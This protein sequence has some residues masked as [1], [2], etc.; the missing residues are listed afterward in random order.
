MLEYI[1]LKQNTITFKE[2]LKKFEELNLAQDSALQ[3]FKKANLPLLN[4]SV[5]LE[6]N[7]LVSKNKNKSKL[8][9]PGNDLNKRSISPKLRQM[10][11]NLKEKD[12]YTLDDYLNKDS[13]L[14]GLPENKSKVTFGDNPSQNFD[15]DIPNLFKDGTKKKKGLHFYS[16]EGNRLETDPN[17]VPPE[18]E[19]SK[20]NPKPENQTRSTVV[21]PE[22]F[23]YDDNG[24]RSVSPISKSISPIS[25]SDVSKGRGILTNGGVPGSNRAERSSNKKVK[26]GDKVKSGDGN[27]GTNSGISDNYGQKIRNDIEQIL[28]RQIEERIKY[29]ALIREANQLAGV[30]NSNISASKP[31]SPYDSIRKSLLDQFEYNQTGQKPG[32][33]G[34]TDAVKKPL[35]D[36]TNS[37]LGYLNNWGESASSIAQDKPKA[38]QIFGEM[39]N[40]SQFHS[41]ANS[42]RNNLTPAQIK[43]MVVDYLNDS[44]KQSGR[45]KDI[46]AMGKKNVLGSGQKPEDIDRISSIIAHEI[47]YELPK[48]VDY[49]QESIVKQAVQSYLEDIQARDRRRGDRD[50]SRSKNQTS[51][52][53]R[54]RE[55]TGVANRLQLAQDIKNGI[56]TD[57]WS[58]VQS[59]MQ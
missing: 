21:N 47:K 39:E 28:E 45:S 9:T 2:L 6:I 13:N 19:W 49:S 1:I 34:K 48:N 41:Q 58:V 56:D 17:V 46:I 43:R 18:D 35:I 4:D 55:K 16:D 14:H 31:K 57:R 29:L 12:F 23:F 11:Q 37:S 53:S 27:T 40:L 22:L 8:K 51:S 50:R 10:Q 33:P 44:Q 30:D 38:N 52:I 20:F 54:P 59:M 7:G 15:I 3:V 36:Q 24:Q 32:N 26:F 42:T 5:Q 25:R